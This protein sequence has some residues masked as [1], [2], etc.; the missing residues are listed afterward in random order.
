MKLN[1][2][3]ETYSLNSSLNL[4]NK[5]VCIMCPEFLKKHS[6][7]ILD[8]KSGC[9]FKLT[10]YN[11]FLGVDEEDHVSCLEFTAP[12]NTIIV[13]NMI[14][15]SMV[16]DYS[17]TNEVNVEL[18]VPPQATKVTFI[19][20]NSSFF[21]TLDIKSFLETKLTHNYKFLEIRQK[22]TIDSFVLEVE[23]LEPYNICFI[24]NTDLEVEF[25]D[26]TPKEIPPPII[27]EETIVN[28]ETSVTIEPEKTE[29]LSREELRKRRLIYYKKMS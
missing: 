25:N 17:K 15:D 11:D 27:P 3:P 14:Y 23:K 6:D 1:I 28:T 18:F 26:Q 29:V 2:L 20:K 16:L 4:S 10:Y 8:N 21:E 5:P 13:S 7:S 12:S 9:L 19:I 22:I 24:N